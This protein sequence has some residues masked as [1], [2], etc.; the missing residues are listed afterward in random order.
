MEN[1]QTTSTSLLDTSGLKVKDVYVVYHCRENVRWFFR[2]LK[3]GFQHVE[4]A[5]PI[6]Y[7]P[8]L[9]DVAW[10]HTLPT[11]ETL[12]VELVT[13]PD[14]P[15]VRCPAS[16]V[17]RVTAMR[18]LGSVRQWFH[19]GPIT[20]VEAV[21]WVLGINSFFVRTPWQLFRYIQARG[22]VIHSGRRRQ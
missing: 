2:G 4:L 6:Y 13:T 21:K 15:W 1:R 19:I 7:G 8:G 3:Y 10:L 17:Q 5:Q 16:T 22:G 14:P 20:C 11:F 18:P 9:S 12:D